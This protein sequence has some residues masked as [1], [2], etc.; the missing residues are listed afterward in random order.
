VPLH[1]P[2]R[3]R[4]IARGLAHEHRVHARRGGAVA[5]K[6]QRISAS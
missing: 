4:Q 1:R 5:R 3:N 6:A 2:L